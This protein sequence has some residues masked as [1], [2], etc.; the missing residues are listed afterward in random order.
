MSKKYVIE[1]KGYTEGIGSTSYSQKRKERL[2]EIKKQL[3]ELEN[4]ENN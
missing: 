1:S 3:A 4:Q 2:E